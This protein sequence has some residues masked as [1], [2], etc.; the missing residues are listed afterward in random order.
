MPLTL[1]PISITFA[2]LGVG[3]I[4]SF[5]VAILA[6]GL[7]ITFAFTLIPS[8]YF[9]EKQAEN[10]SAGLNSNSAGQEAAENET[11]ENNT[12]QPEDSEI[13]ENQT[14]INE[15]DASEENAGDFVPPPSGKVR[16][17]DSRD[18]NG[19]YSCNKSENP[20][21]QNDYFNMGIYFIP[22]AAF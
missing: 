16:G 8:K 21:Y 3:L 20:Y 2:L 19:G 15:S 11:A 12:A 4:G 7:V 22:L 14:E 9:S 1:V 18:D 6:I 10:L 13:E 5:I 17:V